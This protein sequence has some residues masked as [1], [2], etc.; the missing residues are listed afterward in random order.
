MLAILGA[1]ASFFFTIGKKILE[2]HETRLVDFDV[3][4]AAAC[5]GV[6]DFSGVL[7]EIFAEDSIA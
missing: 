1:A 7:Q 3:L 2:P 4:Y 5:R 6:V